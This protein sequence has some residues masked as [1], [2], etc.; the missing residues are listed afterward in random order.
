MPLK[1]WDEAFIIATYLIN[2]LPTHV[3]DNVFPLEQLFNTHFMLHIFGCAC[4]LMLII[5]KLFLRDGTPLS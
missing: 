3:I 4:T 2:Q 1:F 5:D